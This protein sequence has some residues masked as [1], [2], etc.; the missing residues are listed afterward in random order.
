MRFRVLGS[1]DVL[2]ADAPL[3]S[4]RLRRLLAALL[5]QAGAVVSAD[6]LAEVVWGPATP[7]D[8]TAALHT[9][10]SRLRAAFRDAHLD[11]DAELLT[12][13]PGYLLRVPRDQLDA[14]RFEDL[15]ASARARLPDRPAQAAGRL[16][17]ALAL[18]R[19]PAYAEFADD[20]F[21]RAETARLQELR[22]AAEEQRVDAALALGRHGEAVS[23][24]EPLIAEHPLREQPHARLILALSRAGRVAEALGAY[25]AFRRR[26]ADELG[27]EPSATL[28]RLQLDILRRQPDPDGTP[29]D[30]GTPA[31]TPSGPPA[32][33]L[34]V[35][36]TPLVGRQEELRAVLAALRQARV[37]TLTGPGGV[38]KT[39]LAV[40]AAAR[41][42]THHPGGAWLCELAAVT[43]PGAVDQLTATLLG[44]QQRRGRT[45]LERL[46]E[47][48]R[49]QHLLLVVDNCEH[50]L[51]AA[52]TLVQALVHGSPGVSVLATSREPLG[53]DGEHVRPVP[54][55]AVPDAAG[56]ADPARAGQA[57]AVELFRRRAE[58]A[59][60]GFTLTDATLG[61]VAE[62]CRRLDG[63][64]LA[65][66]LAATRVPSMT[67]HEI[68][69]RLQ[70]RFRLLRS[71]RRIAQA[72]HRTL[73]GLVDWSYELL[74]EAERHVF[75][76]VSVFAGDFPVEAAEDVA[77]CAGVDPA[78]VLDLLAALVDKSMVA[79]AADHPPAPGPARTRY[80]LLDTL[81][82]YGRDRLAERGEDHDA[83]R[84]HADHHV[85]LA[86]TAGRRLRGPDE[87]GAATTLTRAMDEL[88]AAHSW[89]LA[90]DPPLA[91]RLSAATVWQAESGIVSELFTWAQRAADAAAAAAPRHPLLPLVHA[92]AAAGA[93]FRGDLDRGN[94]LGE[95][96]LAATT[97]PDDPARA[98]PLHVLHEIAL[99]EGRLEDAKAL[100]ADA[101]RL[102]RHHGDLHLAALAVCDT[103]LAHA[104]A[105]ATTRALALADDGRRLAEETGNPS[106]RGWVT[107]VLGETLARDDPDQAIA[108]LEEAIALGRTLH[109][110]Y[111]AGVALVSAASLRGRHGD[112]HTALRLFRDVIRHWHR[113]GNWTQQWTTVR[114]LTELLARLGAHEAAAVLHG[115]VTTSSTAAPL[116]GADAERLA[117]TARTLRRRLGQ[118][119]FRHAAAR[120]AELSDDDAVAHAC[121]VIE[122]ALAGTAAR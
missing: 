58:A 115:A 62:I 28:Q 44:V 47:F 75:D 64:P 19:G 119:A 46:V 68:L 83:R 23:R 116:F 73:R 26:L 17:E 25:Q 29:A 6:R 45:V 82:H 120:G 42:A 50:V 122:H 107:Y 88:R 52:A 94:A 39:R 67:P 108:L 8:P 36:A 91:L 34:P 90:N 22:L 5:V 98:Y 93:R 1:L 51:D 40:E 85:R 95:R 105:G 3:R 79:T 104:Y 70:D 59:H 72:R 66:E 61:P 100:G 99:F 71:G 16:D 89:A 31:Q 20:D 102:A 30:P 86:E 92:S 9:L 113:V 103:A 96:A 74:T 37:V 77:A 60:P 69:E 110:H 24:L 57:A 11:A 87:A 65:L 49:P 101:E 32:G 38:G 117:A 111:L 109:N 4:P 53:V 41:A 21:A 18:W 56:G 81:R 121:S 14:T 55:L 13:A 27:L 54:P 63:V 48:L 118:D 76:R 112:P 15:L 35:P 7:A 78:E 106:A 12:R 97:G 2:G 80:V 43:D 84:A 33:N 114:N 10:V